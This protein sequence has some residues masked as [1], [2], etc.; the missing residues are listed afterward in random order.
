MIGSVT[1]GTHEDAVELRDENF[2]AGYFRD[3]VGKKTSAFSA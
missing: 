2:N 1:I 3:L